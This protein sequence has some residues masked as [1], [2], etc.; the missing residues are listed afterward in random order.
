M[1]FDIRRPG[2]GTTLSL[3]L[4][5]SLC[6]TS[7]AGCGSPSLYPVEGTILFQDG[8]RA[9]E[10]AGA[11]IDFEPIEGRNSARGEVDADGTFRMGTFQQG[12]GVFPGSYKVSVQHPLATLDRPTQRV[13]D[14]RYENIK[15]SDLRV[16]VKAETNQIT[17][18][19]GRFTPQR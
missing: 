12:D 13:L 8:K 19:V 17:L 3:F 11:T 1:A 7:G 14:P 18:H 4:L 16:T 10:L 2:K 5:S 9:K 15:T 6:L